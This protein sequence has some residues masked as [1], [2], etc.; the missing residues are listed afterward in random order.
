MVMNIYT[1]LSEKIKE[2]LLTSWILVMKWLVSDH[3]CFVLPF[4]AYR[5]P[6]EVKKLFQRFWESFG[7]SFT[8]LEKVIRRGFESFWF[9]VEGS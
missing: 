8:L 5:N 2:N 9:G 4:I 3:E 1:P 7:E 6:L